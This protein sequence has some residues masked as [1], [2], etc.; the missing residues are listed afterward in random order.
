MEFE[1]IHNK[2]NSGT[3][4]PIRVPRILAKRVIRYARAIDCGTLPSTGTYIQEFIET[5]RI[6]AMVAKSDRGFY[7]FMRSKEWQIFNEFHHW[8][9]WRE[10]SERKEF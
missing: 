1:D 2:W 5:K 9:R 10:S 8:V 6:K 7:A 3:T 4:V